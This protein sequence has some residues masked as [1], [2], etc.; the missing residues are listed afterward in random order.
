LCFSKIERGKSYYHKKNSREEKKRKKKKR[1][2]TKTPFPV[3]PQFFVFRRKK[4]E[5]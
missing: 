2:I 3:P 5:N 1:K 4:G